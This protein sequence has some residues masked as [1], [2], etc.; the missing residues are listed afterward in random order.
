MALV[1]KFLAAMS[2]VSGVKAVA[3]RAPRS[4]V[5]HPT[6][7]VWQ[8]GRTPIS[9]RPWL[10]R[11]GAPSEGGNLQRLADW[12]LAKRYPTDWTD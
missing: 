2:T 4:Q 7:A 8:T 9:A 3:M 10:A 6:F 5:R 11:L 12:N 1:C